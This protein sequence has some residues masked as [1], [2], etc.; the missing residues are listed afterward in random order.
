[1]HQLPTDDDVISALVAQY[2][3]HLD[4]NFK[5][6]L[7]SE[8]DYKFKFQTIVMFYYYIRNLKLHKQLPSNIYDVKIIIMQ[9]WDKHFIDYTLLTHFQDLIEEARD[10]IDNYE[11]EIKKAQDE[12]ARYERKVTRRKRCLEIIDQ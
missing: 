2:T 8:L 3:K 6:F 9:S 11:W 7:K 4:F 12:I 10:E 1:V 5:C